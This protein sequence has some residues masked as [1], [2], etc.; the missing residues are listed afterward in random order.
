VSALI[1]TAAR[2]RLAHEAALALGRPAY[3]AF[4]IAAET[5]RRAD[6]ELTKPAAERLALFYLHEGGRA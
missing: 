5:C 6:P 4:A 1:E 3:I 2:V